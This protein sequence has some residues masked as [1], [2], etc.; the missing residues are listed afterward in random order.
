MSRAASSRTASRLER[1]AVG[2][3]GL[4]GLT[5]GSSRSTTRAPIVLSTLRISACAQTAPNS[6]VL[7]PIT[8]A[9]RPRSGAPAAGRE[10]QSRAFFSCP[11]I[12]PLYSG[13]EISTASASRTADASAATA[14]GVG[15]SSSSL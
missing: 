2:P 4:V 11:G 5:D 14:A 9:G 10:I 7:A 6:P 1:Q 3:E 13:V 15:S 8:A 12:D